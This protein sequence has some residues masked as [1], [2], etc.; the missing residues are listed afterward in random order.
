MALSVGACA[1]RAATKSENAQPARSANST[2]PLSLGALHELVPAAGLR[3]MIVGQPQKISENADLNA[4]LRELLPDARF[5]SFAERSGVDLRTLRSA[6]IANFDLGTLYLAEVS[7]KTADAALA[8]FVERLGGSELVEHPH[9][10]AVRVSGTLN[11][12]PRSFIALDRRVV[13]LAEGDLTLSR[14]SIAYALGK[15][16]K[17]PTALR[18]AALSTLPVPSGEPYVSFYAPGP[19]EGEWARAAHGVLAAAFAV[20]VRLEHAE[21]GY[22]SLSLVISGDWGQDGQ[23]AADELVRAFHELAGSSTGKLLALEKARAVTSS[24][25]PQYLTLSAELPLAALVRGLRAAVSADVWEILDLPRPSPPP[26]NSA[27]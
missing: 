21:A 18:G 3:W 16:K 19:F 15:L 25:H 11:R 10:R 13:G 14:I 7:G 24:F 22:L 27:P 17:T 20:V 12:E 5:A 23:S 26:T 4:A 8:H 9:P 2:A 6:L 1:S